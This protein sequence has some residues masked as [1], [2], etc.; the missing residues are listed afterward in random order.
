MNNKTFKM[1]IIAVFIF[2]LTGTTVFAEK[3][4]SEDY[5]NLANSQFAR[6]Q[7]V[8]AKIN[9]NK[10]IKLD[11]KNSKAYKGLGNYY[12]I[13]DQYL[14]SIAAYKRAINLSPEDPY[15][16]VLLARTN[17][18]QNRTSFAKS[19]FKK[20]KKLSKT[21]ELNELALIA[22]ASCNVTENWINLADN[23]YQKLIAL[24]AENPDFIASFGS[25]Y[26]KKG[27][28][29]KAQ[30]L[31]SNAILYESKAG[32]II[33][34]GLIYA[35]Q[36]KVDESIECFEKVIS[37]KRDFTNDLINLI[38][39][40]GV[41]SLYKKA[42]KAIEKLQREKPAKQNYEL[43]LGYLHY[44][45]QGY[46]SA[47][48]H[49]ESE[50]DSNPDNPSAKNGL[51][52]TYYKMA[53]IDFCIKEYEKAEPNFIK[54]V[55]YK[56]DFAEPYLYL[57]FLLYEKDENEGSKQYLKKAMKLNPDSAIAYSLLGDISV[58]NKDYTGA[59]TY[60]EKF[61]EYDP[62]REEIYYN[63][64]QIYMKGQDYAKA[65]DSLQKAL[66]IRKDFP[67]AYR[68][69]LKLD[70]LSL[71]KPG[72]IFNNNKIAGK[73]EIT[74]KAPEKLHK[75]VKFKQ[76]KDPVLYK[77]IHDLLDIVWNDREGRI[78]LSKTLEHKLPIKIIKKGRT[79]HVQ[80]YVS[81]YVLRGRHGSGSIRHI[82]KGHR[83]ISICLSESS[84]KPINDKN[85]SYKEKMLSIGTMVHELCHAVRASIN[86][87]EKNSILEEITAS[88]IGFNVASR[89]LTGKA[90]TEKETITYSKEIL[91]YLLM[92]EHR[93]LPVSSDFIENIRSVGVYPPAPEHYSDVYQLYSDL[94]REM[95]TKLPPLSDTYKFFRPYTK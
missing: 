55:S 5:L 18:A 37:V 45:K 74:E 49:F 64:G 15:L 26:F 27:D 47:I 6:G 22:L 91:L 54:A 88:M 85:L 70:K 52:I 63:L 89:L 32:Y 36:G 90:L 81:G 2:L 76:K 53:M 65:K 7:F 93:K 13:F 87:T 23:Y 30:D 1:F 75:L 50:L 29:A 11:D 62:Y 28:Y 35:A 39:A 3:L 33:G 80:E 82:L 86:E 34:L 92:D 67:E 56:P 95:K 83:E 72:I 17:L 12:Y 4:T 66:V 38:N 84:I 73:V 71:K 59:K 10:A 69:L 24:K 79:S 48:R 61:V 51:A 44:G 68:A 40:R 94:Q 14:Y 46:Q 58:K 77:N 19:N 41:N 16:Y 21:D 78:L 60:F 31:Y 42:I 8:L 43:L 9:Y 20:A 25:R 57:G